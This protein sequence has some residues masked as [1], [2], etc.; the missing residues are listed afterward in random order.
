MM[1]PTPPSVFFFPDELLVEVLSL[2]PVKSLIRFKCVSKYWNTLI[3]DPSF[4]KLHLKKSTT[5]NPYLTLFANH[6]KHITGVSPDGTDDEYDED[7]SIV[8]YPICHLLHKPS[9]TLYVDPYYCLKDKG[10]SCL[11]GSYNGLICLAG[12]SLTD[13]YQDYWLRLWNPATRTISEE[14]GY[15]RYFSVK[16]EYFRFTF[17]CDNLTGIYKVVASCYIRDQ[18]TSEVRAFSFGDNVWRNIESFPIVPLRVNLLKLENYGCDGVFFN[19]T[20]NWL[21]VHSNIE[22]SWLHVQDFTVEQFVIVSLDLGTETYNQYLLPRGFDKVP[23]AEPNLGVLGDCLC[24]SYSYK[25]TD[26]IIWQMKKF[27]VEES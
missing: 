1:S 2:L 27:G 19:G 13:A 10:C 21:A 22:Y 20:L 12:V 9:F 25:E 16:H 23:P 3:S 5:R 6:I 14:L 4:V 24:F 8:P 17:G 18:L 26:F 7:Y 15:F 11:V